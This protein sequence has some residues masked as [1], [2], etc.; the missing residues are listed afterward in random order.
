M[1]VEAEM[2]AGGGRGGW[3]MMEPVYMEDSGSEVKR[4]RW[5]PFQVLGKLGPSNWTEK[6]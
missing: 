5:V 3:E 6:C 4:F 1:G 2:H